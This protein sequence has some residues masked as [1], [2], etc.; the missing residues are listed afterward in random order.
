MF[1]SEDEDGLGLLSQNHD[2]DLKIDLS[3]K[4]EAEAIEIID[5]AIAQHKS[6]NPKPENQKKIWFY[7]GLADG[8]RPTLFA[9]I[10]KLLRNRLKE[11]KIIRAMPAQNGGWI[12]RL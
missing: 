6:Q 7:F 1:N 10:G 2:T 5:D 3:E 9:P 11:G 8:T 12:I 4:S